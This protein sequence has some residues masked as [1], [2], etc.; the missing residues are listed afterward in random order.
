MTM[1]FKAIQSIVCK[2]GSVFR[3][4]I[5][6]ES[7]HTGGLGSIPYAGRNKVVVSDC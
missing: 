7:T 2:G 1:L 3:S 5:K 6:A 4:L